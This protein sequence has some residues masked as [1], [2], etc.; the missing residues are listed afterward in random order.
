L[1]AVVLTGANVV[2]VVVVVVVVGGAISVKVALNPLLGE[3]STFF[4]INSRVR[5]L[6]FDKIGIIGL[7]CE[8]NRT[9]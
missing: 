2:V 7:F 6:P 9:G 1:E 4:D 5:V 3:A 8:Q